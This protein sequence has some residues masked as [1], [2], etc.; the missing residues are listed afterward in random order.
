MGGMAEPSPELPRGTWAMLTLAVAGA[1]CSGPLMASA[2]VAAVA[3]GMWRN[4]L[5]TVLIAPWA[6]RDRRQLAALTRTDRIR[7]GLAGIMLAAHFATW[8]TSLQLTNVASAVALVALQAAWVVLFVWWQTG[9][10]GS[11]VI[12]G[13]VLGLAGTL[14]VS[15]FDLTISDRALYGDL[16]ALAGGVFGAAYV[17][18]GS[19]VRETTSTT[20]Y[21]F[22]CYGVAALGLIAICLVAGVDLYGYSGADWARIVAV[23]L[24]AQIVGHSLVNHVLAVLTPSVV[25]LALLFETPGAALLAGLFLG[26]NPPVAVYVGIGLVMAGLAFV[27]TDKTSSVV[28]AAID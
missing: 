6:W 15:G 13:L 16:L 21:T 25:S 22:A 9:A 11:R 7:I 18:I 5:A 3:V 10:I 27:V 1:C 14:I 19:K 2:A 4:L 24:A 23:T 26:Q 12:V 8:A 20:T 17:V 28:A